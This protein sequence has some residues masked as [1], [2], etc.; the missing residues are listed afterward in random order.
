MSKVSQSQIDGICGGK[1][2][3]AEVFCQTQNDS[4]FS[5]TTLR[6]ELLESGTALPLLLYTAQARDRIA[7]EFQSNQLKLI[8]HLYDTAQ[9]VFIQFTGNSFPFRRRYT[10]SFSSLSYRISL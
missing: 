1:L 9:N 10:L 7:Y 4:G 2:L 3:R 5:V 6:D 8:S